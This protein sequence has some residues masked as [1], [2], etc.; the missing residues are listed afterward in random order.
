MPYFELASFTGLFFQG[1]GFAITGGGKL[2]RV[3]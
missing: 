1:Q 2:K 3:L